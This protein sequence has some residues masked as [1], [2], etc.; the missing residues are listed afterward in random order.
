M[1]EN[2]RLIGSSSYT[3]ELGCGL[4]VDGELEWLTDGIVPS[5]SERDDL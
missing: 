4:V 3:F 1:F 2:S 5:A